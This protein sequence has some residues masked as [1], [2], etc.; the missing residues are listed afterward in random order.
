MS[1]ETKPQWWIGQRRRVFYMPARSL[2]LAYRFIGL[3]AVIIISPRAFEPPNAQFD[4][5]GA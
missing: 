2:C 5:A 4:R 3:E 1:T